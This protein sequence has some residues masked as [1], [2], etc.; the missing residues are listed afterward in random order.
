MLENRADA[1][2]ENGAIGA[3]GA[4]GSSTQNAVNAA[5][6]APDKVREAPGPGP[7]PTK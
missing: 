6:E 3:P 2:R 4:P 7:K 5:A 1:I